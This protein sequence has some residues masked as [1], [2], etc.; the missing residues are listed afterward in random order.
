M[1]LPSTLKQNT[2]S[3]TPL[4][5]HSVIYIC[6]NTHHFYHYATTPWGF[7]TEELHRAKVQTQVRPF[8]TRWTKKDPTSA[9]RKH[10]TFN[11]TNYSILFR[12]SVHIN[13]LEHHMYVSRGRG[14]VT[15]MTQFHVVNGLER[16]QEPMRSTDNGSTLEFH[17][18]SLS[19][20][21]HGLL[22]AWV[23]LKPK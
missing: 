14:C 8:A 16:T 11:S 6:V 7:V 3:R 20:F 13:T 22:L 1:V 17:S 23:L 2:S 10:E 18:F 21:L 19:P 15:R 5:Q 9:R 4:F 12:Y